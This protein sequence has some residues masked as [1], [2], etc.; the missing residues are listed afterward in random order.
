MNN[1]KR[2]TTKEENNPTVKRLVDLVIISV[3]TIIEKNKAPFTE[4]IKKNTKSYI[5][6]Y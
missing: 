3:I 5:E 2:K 4:I 6:Y 1:Q